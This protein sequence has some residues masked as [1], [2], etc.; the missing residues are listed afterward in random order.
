MY[1][2]VFGP[3]EL[4][5]LFEALGAKPE[6]LGFENAIRPMPEISDGKTT[7]ELGMTS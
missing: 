4:Q 2:E 1:R 7:H 6:A 3:S 5:S